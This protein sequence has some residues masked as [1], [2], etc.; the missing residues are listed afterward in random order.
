MT[1]KIFLNYFL[2]VRTSQIRKVPSFGASNQTSNRQEVNGSSSANKAEGTQTDDV[3][4][5]RSSASDEE[6]VS[7]DCGDITD[8]DQ[9]QA[10]DE[11]ENQE[12]EEDPGAANV[13]MAQDAN[14]VEHSVDAEPL[15]QVRSKRDDT[16]MISLTYQQVN[17]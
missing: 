6:E 13:E 15:H 2:N 12:E 11:Q 1:A 4:S 14:T 8:Q 9:V 5:S 16:A 3:G 10:A 7:M 17:S